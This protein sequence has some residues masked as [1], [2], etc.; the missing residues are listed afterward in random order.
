MGRV[1]C[2]V[3]CA[4]CSAKIAPGGYISE[5]HVVRMVWK[6]RLASPYMSI[7]DATILHRVHDE[8]YYFVSLFSVQRLHVSCQLIGPW[9]RRLYI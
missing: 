8:W 7:G 5:I 3:D 6:T 1:S 4:R 9:E 2:G